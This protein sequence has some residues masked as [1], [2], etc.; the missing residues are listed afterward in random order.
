MPWTQMLLMI[1]F[2]HASSIVAVNKTSIMKHHHHS[3]EVTKERVP[4]GKLAF[5]L[6][7][8]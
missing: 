4:S 6:T 8:T 1:Q 3:F 5:D 7:P 2:T